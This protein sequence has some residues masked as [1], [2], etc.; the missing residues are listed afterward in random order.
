MA[1]LAAK[2]PDQLQPIL[3]L[4]KREACC[5]PILHCIG[6]EGGNG[7]M[8]SRLTTVASGTRTDLGRLGLED[9]QDEIPEKHPSILPD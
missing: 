5:I 8:S 3:S 7:G 1:V 9:I 6:G 4:K 2:N